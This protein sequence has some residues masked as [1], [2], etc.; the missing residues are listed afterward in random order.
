M[1][2]AQNVAL[3]PITGEGMGS[4]NLVLVW[5]D[6][7]LVLI[8]AALP[9]QTDGVIQSIANEGF[10][11]ENLTHIIITHQDWDHIGCVT[12]LQKLAPNLQ[13]VAHINE[14]P[15]LDGRVIPIK[16]AT[17]LEQYDE[18]PKEH[19]TNIDL[20]KDTYKN[21]PITVHKQVDDKQVLPICGGIEIVHV[22]GHTP[23]HIAVYLKES[24]IIVC[25]D[26]ANIKDGQ[27][28]GSNPIHTHDMEQANES[29]N[30]IQGYNPS[31]IVAY[32]TGFL[33]LE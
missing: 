11:A 13:I 1:K 26:A 17:R 3:L 32:H 25:G 7:H 27:I 8:D 21:F 29:L 19:Q 14:A 33:S 31:G 10:Q 16:L 20:W 6:N 9:K 4:L 30:K 18:L 15:Y 22:P 12:D 2:L 24:R 28:V 5:D 23:G